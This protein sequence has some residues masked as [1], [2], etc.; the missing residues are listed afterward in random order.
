MVA[1]EGIRRGADSL[2]SVSGGGAP[3]SAGRAAP[4][5]EPGTSRTLSEN[6]TTRP[7][8]LVAWSMPSINKRLEIPC[9]STAPGNGPGNARAEAIIIPLDQVSLCQKP[10]Q[11]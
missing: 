8:S 7:S 6:H 11:I 9:H 5:I 3:A 2:C 10:G 1:C 4:G